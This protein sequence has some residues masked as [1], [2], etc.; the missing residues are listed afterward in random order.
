MV[1]RL[2]RTDGL[3]PVFRL[4]VD[5]FPASARARLKPGGV[6][7]SVT[8]CPDTPL[9]PLFRD[10]GTHAVLRPDFESE[11]YFRRRVERSR[12]HAE[13]PRPPR[14]IRRRAVI[15]ARSG[16]SYR[17][18][19]DVAAVEPV[20]IDVAVNDSAAGT[21]AIRGGAPCDIE[22]PAAALGD[23]V[24]VVTLFGSPA[25]AQWSYL[26]LHGG[27]SSAAARLTVG[28]RWRT[29]ETGRSRTRHRRR[30]CS[31][32]GRSA[33]RGRDVQQG[34]RADS[35]EG[36]S[37]LHHPGAIAPMSLLTY[38]DARPWARS[39]SRRCRPVR[40]RRGTST[41][42]IG[43]SKFKATRH[44]PTR[45]QHQSPG[46]WTRAAPAGNPADMPWRAY[47]ATSTSGTS[48]SRT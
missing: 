14:V 16:F 47:S 32:G 30:A 28:I 31:R 44:T 33:A 26:T 9:Q 27:G 21:C 45:N 20:T 42:H 4:A 15:A 6:A 8:L 43:V 40:C 1:T 38:Q 3:R 29:Y 7:S 5:R 11:S 46:G 12:P 19:L 48:A 35:A 41:V 24:K 34:R 36:V 13:W 39:I 22:L 2:T 37:E 10:G 23:G 18:S 25:P 17:L